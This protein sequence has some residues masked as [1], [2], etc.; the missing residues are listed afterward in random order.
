MG[1][2]SPHLPRLA[3][4]RTWAE[5]D[6]RSPRLL[7]LYRPADRVRVRKHSRQSESIH[8]SNALYQG[9]TLEAAE[10]GR[11][12]ESRIHYKAIMDGL[13]AVP[14]KGFAF[15]R[16]LFSRAVQAGKRD[17]GFR[18]CVRARIFGQ[19]QY[20]CVLISTQNQYEYCVIFEFSRRLFS[21]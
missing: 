10:K 1:P 19:N 11:G 3:V 9:T 13:K 12:S 8:R 4:G 15:F 17:E 5:K 2:P 18:V 21:P 16:N 6:G 7:C 14:F 20:D